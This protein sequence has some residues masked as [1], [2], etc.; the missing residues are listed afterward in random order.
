MIQALLFALT[1]GVLGLSLAKIGL[2]FFVQHF[3]TTLSRLQET[4]IDSTVVLVTLGTALLASLTAT[5]L[6]ALYAIS[7]QP[8]SRPEGTWSSLAQPRYRAL[9]RGA[10]IIFEVW[11]ASGLS[12]VSGLLIKSF[13]EVEKVNLGF[14]PSHVF[15]FQ[16]MPP[17]THYGEPA[18]QSALYKA[19][20]E[21]LASLPGM[22]ST[23]AIS[24]LPLT[25]QGWVN[26]L[27][28]DSQSPLF[29]Q[30]LFVEDESIL[31]GF[32]R[33]ME[34]PLLQGRDFNDT[35]YE[36]SA[37]VI[38]VDDVLAE[39][40]WPGQNALGKH[41]RMSR[42]RGD[43]VNTLEV[44]GVVRQLKHFGPERAVRWMQ[45]YVP[46]YQDPSPAVS[47]IVNT[48][49]PENVVKTAVEK[50]VHDL[51]KDI[52]IE[53]FQSMDAYLD[54]FLTR[55]KVSLILLSAFAGIGIVLGVVGIYG[56]V[57]S[58]VMQRRR[59]IAIRMAVGAS[60]SSTMVLITR[61]GLLATLAGVVIGSVTVLV[62]YRVLA[63]YLFGVSPM[64]PAIYI[65]SAAV[66][67]LLAVLASAVPAM[68]LIRF[69]IQDILRQ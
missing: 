4:N 46:Q 9:G 57:A 45:V 17:L 65:L 38:I 20:V 26:T 22:A 31:P 1:G 54:S 23:S 6:P 53:D 50:A 30:K 19:A 2:V 52:P 15:S 29:G 33:A 25:N 43:P 47:F 66:L 35:D 32:F 64:D 55:R 13:Y 51:D 41:V 10:L 68:R 11:L 40:L 63:A 69:N 28:P 48:T 44:I 59:E 49:M 8:S 67:L 56:V 42:Q 61:L 37:P 12:L 60:R 14:N 21:K 27:E 34:V 7:L 24:S 18:K 62:M 36:G 16:I 39:K 3:P 5:L 58:A